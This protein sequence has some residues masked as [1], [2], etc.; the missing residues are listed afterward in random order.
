[1][2]GARQDRRVEMIELADGAAHHLDDLGMAVADDGAHLPGA[3]I[4][5]APA[6]RIPHEAALRPLGDD[7]HEVAAVADEM[8][9]SLLPERRVGVASRAAAHVVHAALLRPRRWRMLVAP[10][11]RVEIGRRAPCARPICTVAD[12]LP[13][14]PGLWKI[15]APQSRARRAASGRATSGARRVYSI[16]VVLGGSFTDFALFDARRRR[17]SVH[18]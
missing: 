4:E 17:I 6:L 7:G 11:T 8:G 2:D 5:D 14:G 15:A 1:D 3:E 12:R 9:A 18:K 10:A 16:G 13:S